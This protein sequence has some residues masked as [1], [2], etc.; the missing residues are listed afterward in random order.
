MCATLVTFL[1]FL[2]SSSSASS[3]VLWWANTR[4]LRSGT[5]SH[6]VSTHS[7]VAWTCTQVGSDVRQDQDGARCLPN[8]GAHMTRQKRVQHCDEMLMHTVLLPE[9]MLGTHAACVGEQPSKGTMVNTLLVMVDLHT[10]SHP[11]PPPLVRFEIAGTISARC[12]HAGQCLTF[13]G[14]VAW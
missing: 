8:T 10:C 2:S 4:T 1:F 9:L 3:T 11:A 13:A 7:Q 5:T 14:P 12:L 6:R